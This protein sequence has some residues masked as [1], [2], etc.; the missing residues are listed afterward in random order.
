MPSS[1]RT[2]SLKA[3]NKPWR[4]ASAWSLG[5]RGSWII[6]TPLWLIRT[7]IITASMGWK[8]GYKKRHLNIFTGASPIR[9]DGF[10]RACAKRG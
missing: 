6:I 3:H 2:T 1:S 9:D 4:Q 7:H 10:Y 8:F 5:N